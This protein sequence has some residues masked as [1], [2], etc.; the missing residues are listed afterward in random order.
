MNVC[1]DVITWVARPRI[2]L[3]QVQKIN[4]GTRHRHHVQKFSSQQV[5]EID[6]CR[7]TNTMK[8]GVQ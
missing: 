4:T 1:H 6:L 2:L 7:L 3:A 5:G 8:D